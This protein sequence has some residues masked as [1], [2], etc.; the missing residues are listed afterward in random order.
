MANVLKPD[1]REERPW[2]LLA[3]SRADELEAKIQERRAFVID[4]LERAESAIRSGRPEDAVTIRNKL[5]E[6][7]SQYADLADLLGTSPSSNPQPPR[8]DGGPTPSPPGGQVPA[9]AP[10]PD[11]SG[12]ESAPKPAATTAPSPGDR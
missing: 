2:Y 4:Q 6:N 3:V 8:S 12:D 9:S 11:S 1:D 7:Y 10:R 5:R